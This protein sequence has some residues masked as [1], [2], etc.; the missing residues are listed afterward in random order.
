MNALLS[1]L[2]PT[3]ICL[4]ALAHGAI[5]DAGDSS[6]TSVHLA[7]DTL[8]YRG[9]LTEEANSRAFALASS[10]QHQPK[11]I[12]I[13]SEGGSAEAGM[14]LGAWVYERRLDVSVRTFCLASCASY[15]FPAGR[16][17]RLAPQATLLWRWD[18]ARPRSNEELNRELKDNLTAMSDRD[19][20]E[21]LR[22]CSPAELAADLSESHEYLSERE[23]NFLTMLGVDPR[24]TTLG[25]DYECKASESGEHYVGWD[26]SIEDLAVLGV[27][28]VV[29]TNDR[30]WT[31]ARGVMGGK[32]YR[33]QLDR[34]SEFKQPRAEAE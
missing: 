17:K 25:H 24:I 2:R 29:V 28:D 31:P 3:L 11:T 7:G 30:A 4:G 27:H 1:K 22:H 26:Y 19:R 5:A 6:A 13:E 15:V 8:E 18:T 21:L 23:R 9:E 14:Q 20:S 16:I 10:A 34:M 12:L 33:L 32:I